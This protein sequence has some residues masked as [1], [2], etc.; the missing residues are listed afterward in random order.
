MTI[1]ARSGPRSALRSLLT[2]DAGGGIALISSAALALVGANSPFAEHYI[3]ALE[4]QVGGLSIR[5]W[6]NDGLMALFFLLVGLEMKREL[7]DGQLSRWS[8]R[9]L[10][11]IAAIGGMIVPALIYVAL[12]FGESRLR[13]W[14]IPAAT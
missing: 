2:S 9:L 1:S 7:L 6:V 5:H 14:A 4:L 13:G 12:N 10:P 11:G 8:D 3:A